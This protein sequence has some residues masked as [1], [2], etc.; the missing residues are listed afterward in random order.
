MIVGPM[1]VVVSRRV[2]VVCRVVDGRVVVDVR[3]L[4]EVVEAAAPP[5][6]PLKSPLAGTVSE[7]DLGA[8]AALVGVSVKSSG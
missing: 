7:V 2:V 5:D 4:V 3:A 8:P 6:A 1:V